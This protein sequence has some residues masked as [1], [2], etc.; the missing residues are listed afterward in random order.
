MPGRLLLILNAVLL[1][2]GAAG[3]MLRA[4]AN[5]CTGKSA[6]LPAD[7]CGAWMDFYDGTAGDRWANSAGHINC[8][9]TDPCSCEYGGLGTGDTFV[10]M[11][12]QACAALRNLLG[13]QCRIKRNTV[14]IPPRGQSLPT[15]ELNKRRLGHFYP[16]CFGVVVSS[17]EE[18]W[19][20]FQL[21]CVCTLEA[22][23]QL[24]QSIH[25][26]SD[27]VSLFDNLA[28]S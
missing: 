21:S 2:S 17:Q 3:E 8:S 5:S 27:T 9:S 10:R 14:A 1:A 22:A 12:Q 19:R 28:T 15:S 4:E 7:Q 16:S 6:S 23:A 25:L 26:I 11:F 24:A 13:V 20:V 18:R